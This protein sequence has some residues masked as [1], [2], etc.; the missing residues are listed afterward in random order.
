MTNEVVHSPITIVVTVLT[1]VMM[2]L[3]SGNAQSADAQHVQR[4]KFVT[5]LTGQIVAARDEDDRADLAEDLAEYLSFNPDCGRSPLIVN[6]IA[7]LLHD[8]NDAVRWG[9]AEALAHI[10][11]PAKSAVPALERALKESDA[12]LKASSDTMLPTRYSGQAI[13]DALRKIT[14]KSIPDYN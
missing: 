6:A 7:A 14:G 4:C 2:I 11:P 1:C 5:L 9:G 8:R 13:R 3:T 10:G 12:Q